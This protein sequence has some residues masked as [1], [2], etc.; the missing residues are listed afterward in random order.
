[1]DLLIHQLF[2]QQAAAHPEATALVFEQQQLSYGELN[3]RANQLAHYLIAQGIGP[4]QRVAICI[5]RG[6]EMIVGLLG[7]L[8]AGAAYVPLD[9]AYPKDRLDYMLQDCNPAMLLTQRALLPFLPVTSVPLL[10]IDDASA[11]LANQ[12]GTNPDPSAL[13]LCSAHLAYVI[14]TSGSTGMPKGVM[15]EH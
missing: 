1:R 11:V 3:Q 13:G 8:K 14:Y 4:D 7:I 15:V 9:P 2:E 12:P 10:A 6:I 5:E